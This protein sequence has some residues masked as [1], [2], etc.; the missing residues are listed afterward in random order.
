MIKIKLNKKQDAFTLLELVVVIA[1]IATL[2]VV[3]VPSFSSYNKK[4]EIAKDK[5]NARTLYTMATL[6]QEENPSYEIKTLKEEV[7]KSAN[8][9]KNDN[10]KL[11]KSED[12]KISVE[13]NN[14]S[15]PETK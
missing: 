13:F 7:L 4:A 11:T 10:F 6:I 1:I 2:S 14:Q 15:Y 8:I 3:L 5:A 12:G 9:A